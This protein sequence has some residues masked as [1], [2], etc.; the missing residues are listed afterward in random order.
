MQLS[1]CRVVGRGHDLNFK[2][3]GSK[4]ALQKY[5]EFKYEN[6]VLFSAGVTGASDPAANCNEAVFTFVGMCVFQSRA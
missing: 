3:V 2:D 4:T 1:L 5:G 6:V